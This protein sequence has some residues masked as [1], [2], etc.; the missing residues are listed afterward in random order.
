M[1]RH[2]VLAQEVSQLQYQN[3]QLKRNQVTGSGA[4]SNS[5]LKQENERLREEI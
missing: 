1:K 4:Y 5:A 3:E 2:S